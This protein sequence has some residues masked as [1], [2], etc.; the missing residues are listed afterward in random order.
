MSKVTLALGSFVLGAC[1]SF[2]AISLVHTYTRVHAQQ[3]LKIGGAEP[4]VPPLGPFFRESVFT[5]ALQPLDGINCE[6]CTIEASVITYAGGG[7]R[8]VDCIVRS[9]QVQLKGAANNTFKILMLVGAISGPPAPEKTV[10]QN[11]PKLAT[12]IEIGK[13]PKVTWVSDDSLQK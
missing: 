7:F 1:V 9:N 2:A 6:K 10:P 8:C 13:Q 12:T 4:T 3:A 5:G 11:A